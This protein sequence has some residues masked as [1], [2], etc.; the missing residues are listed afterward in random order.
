MKRIFIL[1]F[2]F[3]ALILSMGSCRMRGVSGT[4]YKMYK[5]PVKTSK[6]YGAKKNVWTRSH[7]WGKKRYGHR[8]YQHRGRYR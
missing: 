4:S 6:H 1:L 2:A 7:F 5:Q 8:P 3:F